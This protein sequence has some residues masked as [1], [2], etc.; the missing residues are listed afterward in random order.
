MNTA[1]LHESGWLESYRH[2][3]YRLPA[4][5]LALAVHGAFFTLL[6][7]G[8]S[9]Q[10]MPLEMM[11]VEL[12][13]SLPETVEVP[14]EKPRVEEV[15]PPPQPEKIEQ[16]EIVVPDIK[17]VETKRVEKKPVK[18]K[19]VAKTAGQKSAEPKSVEQKRVE[20]N[21]EALLAEQETERARAE[22]AAAKGRVVNEY[23][24]KI[25][26][27]ITINIVMPPGVPDDA[28]A[29]FRVT[30]L[31]GGSVLSAVMKKS[32][33]NAAYD[34]AVERAILKSDPLP[35]PPDPAMFKDFRILEL[36]FQPRK[37]KE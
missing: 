14:V 37:P 2:E 29:V 24:A 13:Q 32:S 12:W 3:P 30:L 17:K 21:Q 4:G 23:K 16:P 15:A 36:K 9:W 7:F 5:I 27:K 31:P 34:N 20:Q 25:Q 28:L 1:V 33:G 26:N 22:Q 6:Y 19:A 10:V 8:F 18:K 35:L 11:N